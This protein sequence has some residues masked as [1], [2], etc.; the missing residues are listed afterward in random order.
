MLAQEPDWVPAQAPDWVLAQAPDW[1]LEL[2]PDWALEQA[3]AWGL[4]LEQVPAWV[5][6]PGQVPAWVLAP[7]QVPAW[8]LAQALVQ[9]PALGAAELAS[10]RELELVLAQ[11]RTA[12]SHLAPT[13]R[14]PHIPQG[15][16][17]KRLRQPRRDCA[18]WFACLVGSKVHP[19][20]HAIGGL[21]TA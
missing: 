5:L 3:P 12:L 14:H 15:A 16:G 4:A 13:R 1:A 21:G 9:E 20:G 19:N 10:A 7:G 17:W 18:D 8:V 11:A 2:E 6:A